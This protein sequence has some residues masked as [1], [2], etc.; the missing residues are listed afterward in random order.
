MVRRDARIVVGH[1]STILEAT[2]AALELL[3]LTFDQLRMLPPGSLSLDE[4]R[5]ASAGFEAAWDGEGRGPIVGAGSVRLLDGRLLRIRYLITPHPDGTF[6]V[7]I[8]RA[9]EAVSGPPRMYTVG[10][11]LSAWRAAERKLE[12][13]VPGSEEWKAVEA[14]V[15]YFR[16]E[17][18]RA[19]RDTPAAHE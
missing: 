17:Y 18:Q 3:D 12:K 19:A 6:E 5:A 14:E 7:I 2:D 16:A 13:V 11:A 1:D 4:D 8:E 9:D 10:G 15:E